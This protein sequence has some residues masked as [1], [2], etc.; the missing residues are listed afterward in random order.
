VLSLAP[1]LNTL[2]PTC[3]GVLCSR[4]Q[5]GFLCHKSVADL[6]STYT[7]PDPAFPITNATKYKILKQNL[8]FSEICLSFQ[9]ILTG[10]GLL[11]KKNQKLKKITFEDVFTQEL[12]F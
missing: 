10:S 12:V 8:K 7:D 9:T 5:G 4:V 11:W 1:H 6:D 2:S 3:G